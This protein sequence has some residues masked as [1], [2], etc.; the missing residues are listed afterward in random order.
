LAPTLSPSH[1]CLSPNLPAASVPV[2]DR[3]APLT[4]PAAD[5]GVLAKQ[6]TNTYIRARIRTTAADMTQR[7][8]P[9][10]PRH[11]YTKTS[12]RPSTDC[13]LCRVVGEHSLSRLDPQDAYAR[14]LPVADRAPVIVVAPTKMQRQSQHHHDITAGQDKGKVIASSPRCTTLLYSTLS[15][16]AHHIPL[17]P[18]DCSWW[19]LLRDTSSTDT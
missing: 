16:A 15:T 12:T 19:P 18:H 4:A 8:C 1:P 3:L 10:D 5:V 9:H 6:N 13:L 11:I 7:Y 17:P 14:H 2:V